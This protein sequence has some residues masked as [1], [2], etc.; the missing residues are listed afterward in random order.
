MKTLLLT[1]LFAFVLCFTGFA[2]DG[3]FYPPKKKKRNRNIAHRIFKKSQLD[4]NFGLGAVPTFVMDKGTVLVPPVSVGATWLIG[5][6][7]GLDAVVGHSVTETAPKKLNS[8][9][10]ASW[11]N[12]FVFLGI[13]PGIHF[14][15]RDN[16]DIYGGFSMGVHISNVSGESN[17][18]RAFLKEMEGHLGIDTRK[19]APAFS[20]FTGV[21]I[22]VNPKW[23]LNGEVGFG[24][25]LL[26]IGAGYR[27]S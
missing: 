22:A 13:R 8:E 1:S 15:K 2:G 23:T 3:D 11:T 14:T 6:H 26:T 25:S 5:D 19:V 18:D 9:I 27:I 4:V 10:E 12:S 20:G 24:V 21:R 17:G 16:I 7:F